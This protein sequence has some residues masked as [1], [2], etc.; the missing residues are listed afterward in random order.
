[1]PPSGHVFTPGRKCANVNS[2][3]GQKHDFVCI[4]VFKIFSHKH[5]DG[6]GKRCIIRRIF[7]TTAKKTQT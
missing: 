6:G 1:M 7:K 3:A 4:R 2:L 5:F